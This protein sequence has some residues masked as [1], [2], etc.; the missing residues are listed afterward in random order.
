MT[1]AK[2]QLIWS[3]RRIDAIDDTKAEIDIISIFVRMN[4]YQWLPI[5]SIGGHSIF[6]WFE[7]LL[8]QYDRNSFR[9]FFASDFAF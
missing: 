3:I 5:H 9:E 8:F 7:R 1:E 2:H 4:G 6:D